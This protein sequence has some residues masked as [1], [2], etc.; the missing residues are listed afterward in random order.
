MSSVTLKSL[1]GSTNLKIIKRKLTGFSIKTSTFFFQI[2]L[3]ILPIGR[4]GARNLDNWHE[5]VAFQL[6]H[7]YT[8]TIVTNH[9]VKITRNIQKQRLGV[10]CQHHTITPIQKKQCGHIQTIVEEIK[11]SEF[12][13]YRR[14][15]K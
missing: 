5:T 11:N 12:Y 2:H 14:P 3:K 6:H 7:Y 1:P 4:K 9:S 8:R 15:N 10:M 13:Y